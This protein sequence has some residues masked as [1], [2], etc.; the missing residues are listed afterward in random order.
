MVRNLVPFDFCCKDSTYIATLKI[1]VMLMLYTLFT[2]IHFSHILS[3]E[4]IRLYI[5]VHY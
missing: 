5:Y 2:T 3:S 1:K 4:H